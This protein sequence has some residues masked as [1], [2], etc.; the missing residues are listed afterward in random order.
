VITW[1]GMETAAEARLRMTPT[2][3]A[4]DLAYQRAKRNAERAEWAWH[5]PQYCQHCEGRGCENV[6]VGIGDEAEIEGELCDG[7]S[8]RGRCPRCGSGGF[9][10]FDRAGCHCGW[11]YGE[12][13]S[14]M[15]AELLDD[16]ATDLNDYLDP[17]E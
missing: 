11:R 5:W 7:C 3:Q 1:D 14:A 4:A 9:R 15:P 10:F 12:E 8:A 6:L 16:G 13:G 2:E 17:F